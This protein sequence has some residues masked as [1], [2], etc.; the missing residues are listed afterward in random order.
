MRQRP[1]PFIKAFVLIAQL[2]GASFGAH[3][4]GAPAL[5]NA[6]PNAR[7]RYV[8]PLRLAIDTGAFRK[9]DVEASVDDVM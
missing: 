1:Q 9:C 5:K 4:A 7:Q 6:I 3:V 2:L 8:T